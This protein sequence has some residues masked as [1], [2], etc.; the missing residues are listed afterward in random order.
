M[1][2][3]LDEVFIEKYPIKVQERYI[4]Y[5]KDLKFLDGITYIPA[6]MAGL[7]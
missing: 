4:V 6:Y 7:L 2:D 3:F 1:S 5:T